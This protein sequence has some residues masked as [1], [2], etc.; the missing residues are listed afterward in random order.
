MGESR[1]AGQFVFHDEYTLQL[2]EAQRKAMNE[3]AKRLVYLNSHVVP[4]AQ[5]DVEVM[6]LQPGAKSIPGPWAESHGRAHSHPYP[7]MI[8]FFGSSL[9]N[10][11]DL[12]G[13]IEL[14][15]TGEQHIID[16]TFA[17]FIPA[18]VEH[19]PLIIRRVDRPIF[20]FAARTKGAE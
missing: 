13:E 10:M 19:C 16:R 14:W 5:F 7:E 11:R 6:W 20:H 18:G 15:T 9:E 4:G 8:A 12:C 17:A 1:L 2:A 3:M